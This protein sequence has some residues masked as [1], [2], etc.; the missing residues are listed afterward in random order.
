MGGGKRHRIIWGR[1]GGG[2]ADSKGGIEGV[3]NSFGEKEE[4]LNKPTKIVEGP[5]AGG[6][7]PACKGGSRLE[8][9]LLSVASIGAESIPDHQH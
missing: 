4:P 8:S 5:I 7:V 3:I 1:E 2:E 6:G 9:R